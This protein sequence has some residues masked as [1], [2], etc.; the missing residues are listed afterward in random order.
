MLELFMGYFS[1]YM[2]CLD[3]SDRPF[4][5]RYNLFRSVKI[6]RNDLPTGIA[7]KH[8]T[9]LDHAGIRSIGSFDGYAFLTLS[10]KG[11]VLHIV[12][13]RSPLD[14]ITLPPMIRI[15]ILSFAGYM[16]ATCVETF[17]F[18]MVIIT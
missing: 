15:D 12:G 13:T 2:A 14:K 3:P 1:T 8:Y 5:Q 4:S 16:F 7:N 18:F 11:Y 10:N 17:V 9:Q 6:K